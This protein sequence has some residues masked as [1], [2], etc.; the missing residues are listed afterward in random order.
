MVV[1]KKKMFECEICKFTQ[2]TSKSKKKKRPGVI[3]ISETLQTLYVPIPNITFRF[4]SFQH[5]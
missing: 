2:K 4:I 1:P 3:I 5:R